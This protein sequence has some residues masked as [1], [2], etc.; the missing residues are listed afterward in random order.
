MII[1]LASANT[2][3]T[4]H[5]YHFF[6]VVRTFK[7]HSFRNVQRYNVAVVTIITMLHVRSPNLINL[8]RVP[9][10]QHVSISPTHQPGII[11][12]SSP[13]DFNL[14]LAG[15]WHLASCPSFLAH[16]AG[17]FYV[18]VDMCS[19]ITSSAVSPQ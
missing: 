3:I 15:L 18:R 17:Y 11:T 1:T 8:K 19:L 7:I 9:S 2:C 12:I 14:S 6:F 5:N 13:S 10:D 16:R 4:S